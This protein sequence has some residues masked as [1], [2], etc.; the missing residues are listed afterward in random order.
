MADLPSL[1][2]RLLAV[3]AS[4]NRPEEAKNAINDALDELAREGVAP[5]LALGAT[6]PDFTLPNAVGDPVRLADRLATGPVV[7]TFYRG[8]WCPYCNIELNAYQEALPALRAEG[9]HVIAV[10]PQAPDDSLEMRD[11]HDLEFDVL[12]DLGQEVLTAYRVRFVFPAAAVPH[13]LD[14][15]AK[16]LAKQQ[17]DGDWSLPVPAT[18]VLDREGVVRAR[19]VSMAYRTRMEPAEAL[20]VVREINGGTA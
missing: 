13:L 11:K 15:T 6:A 4:V 20:R 12:S 19:H 5:G 7:L 14:A 1:N 16:A 10:S 2:E 18:F 3:A 9:A 8:T 17:P